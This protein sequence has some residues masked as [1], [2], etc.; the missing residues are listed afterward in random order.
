MATVHC[1][2]GEGIWDRMAV[3]KML[4]VDRERHSRPPTFARPSTVSI[5]IEPPIATVPSHLETVA[6]HA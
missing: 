5:A 1:L 3:E 6:A 2:D 4:I